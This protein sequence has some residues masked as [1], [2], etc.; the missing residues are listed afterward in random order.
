MIIVSISVADK[1]YIAQVHT[2]NI[3]KWLFLF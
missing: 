1:R 3:V 2:E